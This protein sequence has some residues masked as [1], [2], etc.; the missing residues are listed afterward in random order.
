M[1]DNSG[2]RQE[3]GAGHERYLASEVEEGVVSWIKCSHDNRLRVTHSA[4]QVKAF[5]LQEDSRDDSN[6]SDEFKANQ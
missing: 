6:D 5:Q 3:K 4:I 2:E 1:S